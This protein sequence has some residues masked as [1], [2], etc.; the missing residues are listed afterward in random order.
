MEEKE[1]K[2]IAE[3]RGGRR[4]PENVWGS[5]A[6]AL[7]CSMLSAAPSGLLPLS[8]AVLRLAFVSAFA[9][10]LAD[11]FASEIGKGYGRTTFLI[12][13][14]KRVPP[15]TEGAVSAEGTAAAAVG[16]GLLAGAA[17]ALGVI[18]GWRSWLIATGAAF[19]ATNVESVIGATIQKGWMTN[20]VVNFV[21]TLVGAVTAAVLAGRWGL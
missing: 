16:G 7:V 4:G 17:V 8:P 18:A 2:G 21:N 10:K 13:S 14:F 19:F 20:E 12:T 15:G 1:K 6:V 5:A 3:G 9:T 11:T